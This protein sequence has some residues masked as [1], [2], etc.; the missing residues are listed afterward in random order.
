MAAVVEHAG[1]RNRDLAAIHVAAKNLGWSR[2]EYR[3]ILRA[4]CRV[5]SSAQLDFTG[6]KQWL[7]HLRACEKTLR[8]AWSGQ[9]RLVWSLWQ[10]LADARLVEHRELSALTVWLKRQ[11]GVDRLEWL[12]GQQLAF[13]VESLKRW[14]E[15]GPQQDAGSHGSSHGT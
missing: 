8:P 5:D 11:T 10:R 13:A 7:A 12:K 6:R 9:Q 3:D 4:V 2:D 14:L 15:R 1:A